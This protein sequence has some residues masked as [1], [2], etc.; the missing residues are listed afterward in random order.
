MKEAMH[1]ARHH[2]TSDDKDRVVKP[3]KVS[4]VGRATTSG[5]I[6]LVAQGLAS[7]L[8]GFVTQLVL[9][10]LLLPEDFGIIGLALT[11]TT[12]ANSLIGFGID[13]VLLQRQKTIAY[14]ETPAFWLSFGISFLGM[15]GMFAIAPFAAKWYHSPSLTGLIIAIAIATPLRAIATV[16]TARIRAELDFRFLAVYNTF[17]I[18]ATQILTVV[19]A[20]LGMGPFAFALPY[21]IVGFLRAVWFWRRSAPRVNRRFRPLHLR[22]LFGNSSYVLLTRTLIELI[23]QGSY[24]VLGLIASKSEIGFYFFAFRF[25]AQPVRMLAGNVTSVVFPALAQF[26]SEPQK[27]ISAVVR[28]C[29]LLGYLVMPFCFLQAALAHPGLHL[30]FG[31]R[32]MRA[33]PYVAILSVGLPFD[34]MSWVSGSLLSARR[35][36]RAGFLYHLVAAPVFF[37]LI[38]AGA[39]LGNV[40]GVAIAVAIYYFT[41]P[42]T[43]T[44]MIL[45]QNKVSWKAVTEFYL[46]PS[47]FSIVAAGVG[48]LCS[49]LPGIRTSDLLQCLV[50]GI[51]MGGTYLGL[52]AAFRRDMLDEILNRFSGITGRLRRRKQAA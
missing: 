1:D 25:S 49:D 33:V 6:W 28:A 47:V 31:E 44:Y 10:R 48:I 51:V 7:R 34:A 41:W 19:F 12:I 27:Q 52:V 30:L 17:D 43:M 5:F 29:R 45:I 18:F 13:E 23:G 20:A 38:I 26:R 16:P 11:V 46:V 40:M 24:I 42:Q 37:A 35:E 9:A 3:A 8:I 36:F 21:P 32:W 15:L 22:Y 50:I 14:W 39:W 4:G 2:H